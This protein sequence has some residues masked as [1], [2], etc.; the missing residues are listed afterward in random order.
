MKTHWTG[1]VVTDTRGDAGAIILSDADAA[2]DDLKDWLHDYY[3]TDDDEAECLS[4]HLTAPVLTDEAREYAMGLFGLSVEFDSK[5]S[6]EHSA[7]AVYEY[8]QD[9]GEQVTKGRT[10][11]S[12]GTVSLAL[13]DDRGTSGDEAL[14]GAWWRCG[15]EGEGWITDEADIEIAAEY[16]RAVAHEN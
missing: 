11:V 1:R 6:A 9:R 2:Y 5:W 13:G 3:E 12:L 8:M 14:A 4:E 10:S 15:D 7:E 16:L